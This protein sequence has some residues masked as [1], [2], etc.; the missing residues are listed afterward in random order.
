MQTKIRLFV[1]LNSGVG[2][3]F[4]MGGLQGHVFCDL[5]GVHVRNHIFKL[6]QKIMGRGGGGV[7]PP[8]PP[9]PTSYATAKFTN[10]FTYNANTYI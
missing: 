3:C 4:S 7:Q 1:H 2:R 8:G 9:P 5:L 6:R 10:L